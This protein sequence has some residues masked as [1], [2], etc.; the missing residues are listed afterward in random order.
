MNRNEA[1][2]RNS[3]VLQALRDL[4]KVLTVSPD[5]EATKVL[6][7]LKTV[8]NHLL[9]KQ[10][11]LTESD[12]IFNQHRYNDKKLHFVKLGNYKKNQVI[13]NLTDSECRVFLYMITFMSQ[14]NMI[15]IKQKSLA[16]DL[17]KSLR[18][19]NTTL[20]GLEDKGV[21][22]KV[23]ADRKGGTGTVYMVNPAIASVGKHDCCPLFEKITPQANL[24]S[25]HAQV[26]NCNYGVTRTET[27]LVDFDGH[28]ANK[29]I[30][31]NCICEKE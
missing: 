18:Y 25:Y 9:K 22:T 20:K 24:D 31:Y 3:S 10:K 27:D 21:I 12:N 23:Y 7:P 2:E 17:S 13:F 26:Q 6:K 29:T 16:K 4:E 1:N 19:V 11:F 30:R 14:E 5:A 15:A 28:G 8:I